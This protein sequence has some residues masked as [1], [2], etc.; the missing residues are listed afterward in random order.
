[1]FLPFSLCF[2]IIIQIKYKFNKK[3]QQRILK[4]TQRKHCIREERGPWGCGSV[5]Q[6][7]VDEDAQTVGRKKNFVCA[8][9]EKRENII[10]I[11]Q[12]VGYRE[13]VDSNGL[14]MVTNFI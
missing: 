4:I 1:M 13:V 10:E 2:L 7:W 14:I 6:G 8:Q 3:K 12:T 11:T 9:F 5:C